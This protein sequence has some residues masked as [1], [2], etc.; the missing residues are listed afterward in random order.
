MYLIKNSPTKVKPSKNRNEQERQNGLKD[1]P[2]LST[3][4][5][6]LSLGIL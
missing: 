5:F 4:P 3:R 2:V 1:V 6:R